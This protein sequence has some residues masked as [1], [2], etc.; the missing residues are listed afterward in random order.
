MNQQR[1]GVIGGGQLAWMMALEAPGLEIELVVQTPSRHDPAVSLAQDVVL[2]PVDDAIATAELA[3]TCSVITFENEFV[4][5]AALKTLEAQGVCFRP[6]LANLAPLLDKFDQRSYLQHIGLPVP[7]FQPFDPQ[8]PLPFDFPFVLKARRYG[9]DGQGTYIIHNA[10]EL[11]PLTPRLN[12]QDWL[13]E[14]FIP[15]ERELALMAAR[16]VNG[17]V[18]LYPVVETQQV[19]QVCHSV[20]APAPITS[21]LQAEIANYAR[22]LLT[23]LQVV[24]IF[25]LELFLT[26]AGQVLVNEI[27]P[28]THNSGHYTLDAC[29]LSQFAMQL[30]AVTGKTLQQPVLIGQQAVMVNLLGYENAQEDYAEKRAQLAAIPNAFVHWYNKSESRLGRKLGHVT[31]LLESGSASE[32]RSR[33][34]PASIIKKIENI[35]YFS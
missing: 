10:E 7:R 25:G 35:W 16:G 3:K 26:P 11:T 27:A 34:T 9:Y 6:S 1:V 13:I 28:R 20:I 2:A 8:Q 18:V 5:L 19:N 14:E 22:L 12:A 15:F 33:E 23:K 29:N 31:V 24:G 21:E 17:E 30:Q 32:A 4:D